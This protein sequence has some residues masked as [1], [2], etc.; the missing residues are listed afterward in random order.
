MNGNAELDQILLLPIYSFPTKPAFGR[1][2]SEG[3]RLFFGINF[4]WEGYI[5]AILSVLSLELFSLAGVPFRING[6]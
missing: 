2:L 5:V 6:C 1:Q 4:V 3:C